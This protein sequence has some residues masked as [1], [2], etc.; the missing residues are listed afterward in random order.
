MPQALVDSILSRRLLFVVGKGGTGK[1]SVAAALALLASQRRRHVLIIDVDTKG[2]VARALG[3][4]PGGFSPLLV[5]PH[6]YVVE[7][8]REASLQEYLSV[9]YHIPRLARI[10]PLARVLDF[11]ATSVPG[12]SDMLVIGKIAYEER[13]CRKDGSPV[14]DQ[15][16]VDSAASGHALPQIA[17]ARS[18]LGVV[19]GGVMQ[20]QVGWIDA[21]VSDH[22]K[23][24]MVVTATPEEMAVVEAI[25]LIRHAHLEAGIA[26]GCVV[27]NRMVHSRATVLALEQLSPGD[28]LMGGNPAPAPGAG[29]GPATGRGGKGHH[30]TAGGHPQDWDKDKPM[31]I[32][33]AVLS[34]AQFVAALAEE[35]DVQ[36]KQLLD[37]LRVPL[38]D[39]PL[40]PGLLPGPAMTRAMAHELERSQ[41]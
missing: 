12:A 38:A 15:I 22:K 2:D 23:T 21:I 36:Q 39:I 10:G 25:D 16:I 18:M 32:A 5:A 26:V 37:S 29:P 11:V 40:L 24:A 19:R 3:H 8:H 13:R 17:A 14:W 33:E 20:S 4:Q 9:Y 28:L 30:R 41:R 31:Q 35:A 34:G 6:I 27:L 1:S 7:L